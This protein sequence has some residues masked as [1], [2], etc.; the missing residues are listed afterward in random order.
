MQNKKQV[1]R[2]HSEDN[3]AVAVVELPV[4]TVVQS[5]GLVIQ[6]PIPVGHKA[7]TQPIP[8]GEPLRKYGQIIGFATNHIQAGQHVHTHNTAVKDFSRD[9]AFGVDVR[10]TTY[11]AARE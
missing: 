3:V 9:Y 4:G 1:I 2:L 6:E 7:A 11:V 5:E 8:V 10:P